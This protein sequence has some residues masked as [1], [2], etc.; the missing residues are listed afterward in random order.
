MFLQYRGPHKSVL[1]CELVALLQLH[2]VDACFDAVN[3][4]Y[5]LPFASQVERGVRT[6]YGFLCRGT[7]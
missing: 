5:L 6:L 1:T 7:C 4:A 3:V 2:Y